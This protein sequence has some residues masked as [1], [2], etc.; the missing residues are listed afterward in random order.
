MKKLLSLI[1]VLAAIFT[2]AAFPQAAFAEN[3]TPAVQPPALPDIGAMFEAAVHNNIDACSVSIQGGDDMLCGNTLTAVLSGDSVSD[4]E[5]AGCLRFT[6]QREAPG[7]DDDQW[8]DI[9]GAA[10][11]SYTLTADD[12][13]CNIRVC[14]A[15][16]GDFSGLDVSEAVGPV[17]KT[18][19]S[20]DG[21]V[22]PVAASPTDLTITVKTEPEQEYVLVPYGDGDEITIPSEE[23]WQTAYHDPDADS[24]WRRFKGLRADTHYAVWTRVPGTETQSASEAVFNEFYTT[25]SYL[26]GTET[27]WNGGF[28]DVAA[29]SWYYSAVRFTCANKLLGGMSPGAFEPDTLTTRAMVVTVLWR[30]EDEPEYSGQVFA[31]VPEG[32]WYS[33]AVAWAADKGIVNGYTA[34]LFRP[35]TPVTREELAAML[36]RYAASRGFDSGDYDDLSQFSD[37]GSVRG[38]AQ[39]YMKW[40]VGSGLITGTGEDLL[41]PQGNATRAQFA[42]MLMRLLCDE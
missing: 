11:V 38:Y 9:P 34:E 41:E 14:A 26:P 4:A 28:S 42:V 8:E 10:G 24:S 30:M 12:V 5:K 6:W 40:A 20:G 18:P 17:Q 31:D 37:A 36:G 7:A 2:F 33:Q 29:D 22:R 21:P 19:Y 39:E 27:V 13:G 35:H 23:Q 1:L 3:E 25:G 32:N 15:A 16:F